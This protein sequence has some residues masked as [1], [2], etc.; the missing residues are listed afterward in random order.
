M[1]VAKKLFDVV[2]TAVLRAITS[3]RKEL[4]LRI[5]QTDRNMHARPQLVS[6]LGGDQV[7]EQGAMRV[8]GWDCPECKATTITETSAPVIRIT[9]GDYPRVPSSFDCTAC[10]FYLGSITKIVDRHVPEW[11]GQLELL[12]SIRGTAPTE[13]IWTVCRYGD[14][15]MRHHRWTANAIR[16]G[17]PTQH[18]CRV[19][20]AKVLAFNESQ[21][22]EMLQDATLLDH[23]VEVEVDVSGRP[24]HQWCGDSGWT[25]EDS[26]QLHEAVAERR[27]TIEVEIDGEL[28]Q[29]KAQRLR[30]AGV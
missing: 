20:L 10:G 11:R 1:S 17:L 26:G 24:L 19:S 21:V 18:N 22:E 9:A 3:D 29:I 27:R 2:G 8:K 16:A 6:R 12:R 23:L 5:K 25:L 30:A 13:Q 14:S 15:T 7:F 28:A 4:G